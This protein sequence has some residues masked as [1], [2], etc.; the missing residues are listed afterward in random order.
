MAQLKPNLYDIKRRSSSHSAYWMSN[1]LVPAGLIMMYRYGWSL[2]SFLGLI[3]IAIGAVG[4][5]IY[6][7]KMSVPLI[8]HDGDYLIY[9]PSAS[10]PRSIKMDANAVF[11][12]REL[13]LTAQSSASPN[14]KMEVS[15]LD[16]NSNED[17]RAFIDH[18]RREPHITLQ[19]EH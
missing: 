6:K 5:G 11:T 16:F 7:Q 19:F 2:E 18:L 3:F 17:W 10:K 12:V 9:R 14:L 13:G 8:S 15:L 4:Y 1:A